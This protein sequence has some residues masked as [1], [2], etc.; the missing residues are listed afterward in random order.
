MKLISQKE[1]IIT[2]SSISLFFLILLTTIDFATTYFTKKT[3]AEQIIVD[4]RNNIISSD[5]RTLET[6]LL[7]RIPQDFYAITLSSPEQNLERS[8]KKDIPIPLKVFSIKH[9]IYYD[10]AQTSL[11]GEISF[12]YDLFNH[13]ASLIY[14]WL[15]LSLFSIPFVLF[16][17]KRITNKA[18]KEIE[19]EK[20]RTIGAISLQLAHDIRSPLAVLTNLEI[21][22]NEL[23]RSAIFRLERI[24]NDLLKGKL[25]NTTENF[26]YSDLLSALVKEKQI[27]YA[28]R[29]PV[30][31]SNITLPIY[32]NSKSNDLTRILSNLLNNA[33]EST[34]HPQIEISSK[35]TKSNFQIFIKDNGAGIPKNVLEKLGKETITTKP[36]GN[37]LGLLGAFQKMKEWGGELQIESELNN[38]TTITLVFPLERS[39]N[40]PIILVDDDPLVRLNWES[41]A[42]K[43]QIHFKAYSR[44]EELLP[45]FE[46]LPL[47]TIFYLDMEIKN[48]AYSG[49]ELAK[50]LK[51]K[52]FNNLYLASGHEH[53]ESDL[54]LGQQS[55]TCPF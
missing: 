6:S 38:G 49:I 12:E 32:L 18:L 26:Q 14:I 11:W 19:N 24:A 36:E 23:A 8:F 5:F 27:T 37:G 52:G 53:I 30:I 34:D 7:A 10:E 41:R 28:Q 13:L 4:A 31:T 16:F 29:C 50:I 55:K 47:E 3:Q 9:K 22:N 48:S 20:L 1:I 43:A 54:F 44:S 25:A 45:I 15:F 46:T 2:I 21:K 51:E 42:K 17:F 33:I 35:E 39:N 40:S